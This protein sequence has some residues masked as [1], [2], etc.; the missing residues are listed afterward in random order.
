MAATMAAIVAAMVAMPISFLDQSVAVVALVA[1]FAQRT[2]RCVSSRSSLEAKLI[3]LARQRNMSNL[4]VL[5]RLIK[6][7]TSMDGG[8]Y[9]QTHARRYAL[10][11]AKSASFHSRTQERRSRV[12]QQILTSRLGVLLEWMGVA[13][14]S[15]IGIFA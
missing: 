4:G 9:A 1:K 5:Q 7:A 13:I 6:M 8:T 14:C 12:A 3:I 2:D 10:Q 15:E 11:V